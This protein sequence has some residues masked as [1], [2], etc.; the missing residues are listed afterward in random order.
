[1]RELVAFDALDPAVAE[2]QVEH[3]F[4]DGVFAAAAVVGRAGDEVAV[5]GEGAAAFAVGLAWAR[6]RCQPGVS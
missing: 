3:P 1:M 5:D 2:L 4:T 6:A